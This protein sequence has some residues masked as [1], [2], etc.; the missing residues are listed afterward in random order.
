MSSGP[1][2]PARGR[3]CQE[4]NALRSAIMASP[5]SGASPL[6]FGWTNLIRRCFNKCP[7]AS[8]VQ[9]EEFVYI[10]FG[11]LNGMHYG[12]LPDHRFSGR[13]PDGNIE[14]PHVTMRQSADELCGV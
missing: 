12:S 14:A 3:P 2:N 11:L 5:E 6:V 7:C 10:D 8:F 9:L 13:T 1:S 4:R